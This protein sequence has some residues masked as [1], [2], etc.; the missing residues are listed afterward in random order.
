MDKTRRYYKGELYKKVELK[1]NYSMPYKY[2]CVH[3]SILIVQDVPTYND[4]GSKVY[5]YTPEYLE[6]PRDDA[7]KIGKDLIKLAT[8]GDFT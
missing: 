4:K 1:V 2:V 6:I 7:L 3:D 8:D 5:Y